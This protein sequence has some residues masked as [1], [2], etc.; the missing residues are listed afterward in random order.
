MAQKWYAHGFRT[1]TLRT[2]L[3]LGAAVDTNPF[4]VTGDCTTDAGTYCLGEEQIFNE[5]HDFAV[6]QGWTPDAGYAPA[7][8]R[9]SSSSSCRRT[10]RTASMQIPAPTR[11]GARP[12]PGSTRSAVIAIS[13]APTTRP[14]RTRRRPTPTSTRTCG[15]TCP[16]TWSQTGCQSGLWGG[17]YP[18]GTPEVDAAIDVTSHEYIESLTDPYGSAWYD[19]N[20]YEIADKCSTQTLTFHVP[21]TA[22]T[23]AITV[24]NAGGATVSTGFTVDPHITSFTPTSGAQGAAITVTGSGFGLNGDTRTVAVGG[25]AATSVTYVST[26]SLK[27]LIPNGAPVSD[28]IHVAVNGGAP[29]D[30]ATNLSVTATIA[31]FTPTSGP[32]GTHVTIN[33]A[34]FTGATGVKFNGVAA[35]S[36]GTVTANTIA[37]VVVPPGTTPGKITITRPTAPTTLTSGTNFDNVSSISGFGGLTH[38]TTGTTLEIDGTDL[39]TADLV[40]FSGGAT[41]SSD[42]FLAVTADQ[43]VVTIPSAA[44]SG[45]VTVHTSLGN[46]FSPSQLVI[47]PTITGISPDHGPDGTVVVITGSGFSGV[48]SVLFNGHA[49]SI[50]NYNSP[51]QISATI[52]SGSSS[53]TGTVTVSTASSAVT[54]HSPSPYTWQYTHDTGINNGHW[55]DTTPRD[56]WN[57]TEAIAAAEAWWNGTLT[58]GLFCNT[59]EPAVAMSNGGQAAVWVYGGGTSTL[60]MGHVYLNQANTTPTCPQASDPSWH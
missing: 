52:N 3:D 31:S 55:Y 32:A 53:Y 23:G 4:P 46:A 36:F 34:G 2:P 35:T 27:L 20:G 39:N 54:A 15:R 40:T 57:Q 11:H 30:S 51:T 58:T 14:G 9:I 29:A 7:H 10:S 8:P 21:A 25:V 16:Y 19:G 59:N 1:E 6:V 49:P 13:T 47:D 43:V 17:G 26:T 33:G 5:L 37:N 18:N 45:T 50:W 48:N 12:R 38:A 28:K 22:A 24:T 41:V 56:T 44:A 60:L 42:H